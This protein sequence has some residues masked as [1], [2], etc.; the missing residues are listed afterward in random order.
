MS[1]LPRTP[2]ADR[3]LVDQEHDAEIATA[4]QQPPQNRE[5]IVSSRRLVHRM[6]L[7]FPH[8]AIVVQGQLYFQIL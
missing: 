4:M 3:R 1:N 6:R 2:P 5:P 7:R 8:R